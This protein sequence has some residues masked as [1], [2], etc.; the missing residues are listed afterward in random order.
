MTSHVTSAANIGYSGRIIQIECDS[1]NGLPGLIIVGLGNKAIEES[2]E[3][4]RSAIKN[5]NLDFPRKRVTLNLAPADLPKDGASYDLPMAI[6]IL[7]ISG[8]IP[9]ST[10]TDT[11]FVGELALNGDIR[12]IRGII[13]YLETAKQAGVMTIVIPGGNAA[14]AS[15]IEG[16]TIV[17]ANSLREL[18][19]HLTGERSIQPLAS[20]NKPSITPPQI[21]PTLNDIYGQEQA[22]RALII[23]AA[24]RHN[25]LL[26]GP[27]GAGK[28]MLAK[29]LVSILPPLSSDEIIA[30]TKLHSLAGELHEDIMTN[31]PFRAPHHTSSPIALIGGGRNP[32]PGEISL[33]HYGVLF[34]DELPEY[35][36]YALEAL[37]QPLEDRTIS[38]SR[39][40]ERVT[41]PADFMLVATQNPCPCGYLGDPTHECTC[42]NSQISNYQ[43]RV[44]GPL[45][46]RIDLVLRV[47]RVGQHQLLEKNAHQESLQE[48]QQQIYLAR[49]RQIQ[50]FD[51]HTRTNAHLNSKELQNCIQ[52][53]SSAKSFLDQAATKLDLSAR[54]YMKILRVAR[55]IADLEDSDN[56]T[57]THLSEALQYRKRI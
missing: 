10:I 2:K 7:A 46:D 32:R 14:Q 34:L 18:F 44:S 20:R 40:N 37:R 47:N 16:V 43:K 50:R 39:A 6:A 31:R 54:A 57:A 53:A 1:S 27:P 45:L 52:L 13:S 12:P 38:I 51:S 24:G 49:T 29:A 56:I 22:K 35:P 30:I 19:L 42:S 36:R 3:R 15:L 11:L 9:E 21:T 17:V 5:S 26:H 8:Q 41:Y 48:I 33:A 28:T 25:L 4:I 23:A 55:T